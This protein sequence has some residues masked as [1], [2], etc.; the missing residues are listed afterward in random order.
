MLNFNERPFCPKNA[1]LNTIHKACWMAYYVE[2][3]VYSFISVSITNVGEVLGCLLGGYL[4]G[5]FGPKKTTQASCVVVMVGWVAIAA[6]PH[7]SLLVLGRFLTGVGVC[8]Q[9]SNTSL[10]VAQYRCNTHSS[11]QD[12]KNSL[13]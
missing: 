12:C 9:V 8:L 10:L 1:G 7:L 13:G 2:L 5:R 11:I 4:G 6:S 3:V